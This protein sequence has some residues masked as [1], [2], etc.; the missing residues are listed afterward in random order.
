[1]NLPSP[2]FIHEEECFLGER[3]AEIESRHIEAKLWPLLARA[4]E[5]KV[6]GLVVFIPVELPYGTVELLSSGFDDHRDG[7]A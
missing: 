6:V 7:S 5:E 3:T 1:M 2:L 4:V